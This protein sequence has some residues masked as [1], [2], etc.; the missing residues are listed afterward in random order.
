M[1][2]I[3]DLSSSPAFNYSFSFTAI[4]WSVT[5]GVVIGAKLLKEAYRR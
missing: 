5:I 1:E 2:W 4:V 3:L